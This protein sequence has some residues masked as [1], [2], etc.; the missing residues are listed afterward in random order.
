MLSIISDCTTCGRCCEGLGIPPFDYDENDEPFEDGIEDLEIPESALQEIRDATE[1]KGW[2]FQPCCWFDTETRLCRHYEHR[3][4]ACEWFEPGNPSCQEI[5]ESAG[6][7][8]A[9]P[10]EW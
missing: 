2:Q 7:S 3:P 6:L 1:R 8:H 5:L 4:S 9:N 10:T